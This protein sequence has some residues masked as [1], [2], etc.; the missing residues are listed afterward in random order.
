MQSNIY[1]TQTFYRS[2]SSI[3]WNDQMSSKFLELQMLPCFVWNLLR[4][5]GLVDMQ[6]RIICHNMKFDLRILWLYTANH[7]KC[8]SSKSPVYTCK[9]LVKFHVI[10]TPRKNCALL[11]Y[12]H[13]IFRNFVYLIRSDERNI[14]H[15]EQQPEQIIRQFMTPLVLTHSTTYLCCKTHSVI[16]I[17]GP[18]L[19]R[20]LAF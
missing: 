16:L 1:Y 4:N 17:F 15:K 2:I 10:C 7:L 20:A 6:I 18:L 13:N 19:S 3:S 12:I 11:S 14:A 9:M 5:F 8:W